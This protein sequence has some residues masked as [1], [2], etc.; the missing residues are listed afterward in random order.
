MTS[1][2]FLLY[3]STHTSQEFSEEQ[4]PPDDRN[5]GGMPHTLR[6]SV[7][8]RIMLLRNI[9]TSQGLVNGALGKI[10]A[11]EYSNSLPASRNI[12]ARIFIIFDDPSVGAVLQ[13]P[14]HHNAIAIE[15]C[16][17]E[18]F[19]KGR[20]VIRRQFPLNLAWAVTIHRSQGASLDKVYCDLGAGIF[21]HGMAYVA[22][23][24][25]R[26][27]QG[28]HLYKFCPAKVTANPKVIKFYAEIQ[29]HN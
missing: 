1:L 22:M 19:Y 23:S 17:Q 20:C 4:I 6:L 10:E 26:T 8:S 15:P 27:L 13:Q 24:R 21:E 12:P 29:N 11:V 18:Y 14:L 28:L 25:V 16:D 7:G 3:T 9:F 2:Q 5:A